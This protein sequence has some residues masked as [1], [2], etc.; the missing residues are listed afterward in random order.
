M[1]QQGMIYRALVASPSDC[2]NERKVVPETIHY[3]NSINSSPLA[4][5]IEPILWE[6]HASPEF[7]NRPQAII[8]KQLVDRC[9]I[10]I[11]TFW[12]RLGSPTG[13]APSGTVEEIE[14]FLAAGKPVLLYFSLVPVVAGSYDESQYKALIEYREQLRSR[15]LLFEY[16]TLGSL[17]EQLLRHLSATMT[18]L[19]GTRLPSQPSMEV[20][21][22]ALR[23]FKGEFAAFLRRLEAAWLSERDSEP[24]NI[25]EGKVIMY[26]ALNELLTLRAQMTQDSSDDLSKL[27]DDAGRQLR[28]LQRHRLV[29]DGGISFQEFWEKGNGILQLLKRAN[30]VLQNDL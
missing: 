23:Q 4:A 2:I 1:A 9:D 10:L 24:Y 18:E 7:G 15:G 11:G 27:L 16:D 5:I 20:N 8:N 22:V 19:H 3:W 12:T 26:R 25:D 17:R 13:Q 21:N 28:E 14:R 30:E 29:M 6:T